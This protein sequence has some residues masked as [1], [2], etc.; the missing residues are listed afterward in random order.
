M[1]KRLVLSLFFVL[2]FVI[3][4]SVGI[5]GQEKNVPGIPFDILEKAG[6]KDNYG[7]KIWFH[8]KD[9]GVPFYRNC[10]LAADRVGEKLGL[11]VKMLAPLRI[12]AAAEQIRMVEDSIS[13]YEAGQ[14]DG[15]VFI[16]TD[17]VA[18]GPAI[19]KAEEAGIPIVVYSNR[20][21]DPDLGI[22]YVGQDHY[23]FGYAAAD[24]VA[25]RLNYEGKVIIL[26]GTPASISAQ[27]RHKG[28]LDALDKYPGIE[29][30]ASQT[31]N[32]QRLMAMEVMET[33]LQAH[34]RIDAVICHNDGMAM[35]AIEAIEAAGRL[36]EIMVT[37]IDG[38]EDALNSIKEGKMEFTI[39]N[40][41]YRQ[42]WKAM[43]IIVAY[44]EGLEIKRDYLIPFS[45]VDQSN[46]QDFYKTLDKIGQPY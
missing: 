32:Y 11:S 14:F 1:K 13:A 28:M 19:R 41:G 40:S 31:A 17:Y 24:E 3:T 43:E 36:D 15:M 38:M 33:L 46:I 12:D 5:L 30:I 16:P 8:V 20:M 34:P 25:K 42:S 35:G 27:D 44:L 39:N 10:M 37:G 26:E 18:L 29:L 6:L 4:C 7:Y 22:S 45:L 9:Y 2:L 23:T 21:D